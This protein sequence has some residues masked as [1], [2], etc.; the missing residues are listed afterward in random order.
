L[1][2]N[3]DQRDGRHQQREEIAETGHLA[4][5]AAN[6][7]SREYGIGAISGSVI[8]SGIFILCCAPWISRLIRFFPKGEEIAETG[9]LA[10]AAANP[11]SRDR[12]NREADQ[13]YN[14]AHL[15]CAPWISRLIRFFPKVVMGG[16]VTL[17]GL[18]IMPVA[19]I[20]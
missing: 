2:K 10:A 17:I 13:R 7:S 14:A 12:H 8:V 4:A 9:H 18:S 5:A 11:S 3:N 19:A 1:V 6:P 16:I 15:C 20:K